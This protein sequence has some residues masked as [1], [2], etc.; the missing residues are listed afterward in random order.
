LNILLGI[1]LK[2]ISALAFTM[3]SVQIKLV[4][5]VVPTGQVM[6]FR[7]FFALIPLLAWMASRG[8]LID[9][10]RTRN[11]FGHLRRSII[12]SCGMFLGF[13]ALAYLPLPDATAIGYATPLLAT[14]LATILLKETVDRH[15][16]GGLALGFSGMLVMLLPYMGTQRAAEGMALGA[17]FGLA[18][19]G[20]NAVASTEIRRLAAVERTGA[21]VFYFSTITAVFGLVASLFLGWHAPDLREATL[22]VGAGIM[23]GIGQILVTAS[24][25][26]APISVLAPFD[27][28]SLLWAMIMGYLVFG[29]VPTPLVLVGA[30]IV[31]TA[32]LFVMGKERARDRKARLVKDRT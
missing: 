23:G 4:S 20:C 13:I 24:Y 1:T 32:G 3:M 28:M 30:V 19:A 18:A 2:I 31:V 29:D 16:W 8:E 9:A 25:R 22:L 26:Y 5:A 14:V 15:R 17:A 12:G 27:Y 21:I 7:S 11:P 6:F 10:V